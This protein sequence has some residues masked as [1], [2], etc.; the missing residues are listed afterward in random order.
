[1]P[2]HDRVI[3][4]EQEERLSDLS[5]EDLYRTVYQQVV[6]SLP[7]NIFRI[8]L[9]DEFTGEVALVFCVDEINRFPARRMPD[10]GMAD[11][12]LRRGHAVHITPADMDEIFLAGDCLQKELQ[13]WP[14]RHCL[15][16]PLINR[17]GKA[18]GVISLTRMGT[19]PEQTFQ[20]EDVETIANI[21]EQ[22]ARLIER[23]RS[24]GK[25]A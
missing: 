9:H 18:F 17:Q 12:I 23:K 10:D 5:V 6:K 20:T 25:L 14:K 2:N 15:G 3:N 16:A 22:A 24:E 19:E 4:R 11:F 13:D 1:M 7:A 21:A 8:N